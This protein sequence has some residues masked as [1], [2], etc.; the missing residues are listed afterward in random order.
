MPDALKTSYEN[1]KVRF[2]EKEQHAS[3][4]QLHLRSL[5][6]VSEA[7]NQ[8]M[9]EK[10]L[11]QMYQ[12]ILVA[13]LHVKN[14]LLFTFDEKWNCVC[15]HNSFQVENDLHPT[16]DFVT[17]NNIASLPK[18]GK[19]GAHFEIIISIK[20]KQQ[21]I[22]YVLLG[23]I[24]KSEVETQEEKINFIKSLTNLVV[25]SIDNK[26]LLKEQL[27]REYYQKE[28]N[29]AVIA[30]NLLL[31]NEAIK[32]EDVEVFYNYIPHK[33]IGGDYYD[34]FKI[35]DH[36]YVFCI[37]DVAGK[38]VASGLIMSN[39]QA[40]FKIFA[41]Q[42]L[43]IDEFVHLLNNK[44]YHISNGEKHIT[45]LIGYYNVATRKL[46]YVNAG[47]NASLLV[48]GNHI[49]ELTKGTTPLGTFEDLLFLN[50]GEETI[51][52]EDLLFNYTDGLI[53]IV[54][55]DDVNFDENK[56]KRFILENASDSVLNIITNLNIELQAFKENMLFPDD[57]STMCV[58]FR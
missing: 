8:N 31:P 34:F 14:L 26:R 39:F 52:K 4:M 56:L 36:G 27:E 55:N 20:R 30:Q 24:D 42:K 16:T 53:D 57:V 37:C 10:A 21:P 49:I 47:H 48:R 54:N 28:M 3:M 2:V 5:L 43:P 23:G 32:N 19:T 50:I 45:A 22:A 25:A 29:N 12:N 15:S 35:T 7:V 6:Q 58:R 9:P 40:I 17:F 44:T 41:D 11:Y 1:L 46:Q 18:D 13:Q 51:E 38:G 33:D